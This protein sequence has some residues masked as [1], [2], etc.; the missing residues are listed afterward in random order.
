MQ[1]TKVCEV[2]KP[3][4]RETKLDFTGKLKQTI[5]DRLGKPAD[6]FAVKLVNIFDNT[7]RVNVYRT[8]SVELVT[9][10][11][12]TDSFY[13]VTDGNGEITGGDVIKKKY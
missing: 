9:H 8:T 5:L 1:A 12:I 4:V 13:L 7:F 2:E 3:V 6:L 11:S 10:L